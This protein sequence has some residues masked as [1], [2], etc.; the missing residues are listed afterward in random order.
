[1]NVVLNKISNVLTFVSLQKEI[2][3]YAIENLVKNGNL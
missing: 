3:L 1:M 2:L